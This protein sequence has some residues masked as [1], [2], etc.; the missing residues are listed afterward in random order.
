M[1][2]AGFARI[3]WQRIRSVD[4]LKQGDAAD[5]EYRNL[6]SVLLHGQTKHVAIVGGDAIKI[7]DHHAGGTDVDRCAARSG[8]DCRRVGCIHDA[9]I[10]A[11]WRGDT[12]GALCPV[13]V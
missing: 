7:A 5:A 13:H 10:W 1:I 4:Q 6:P 2:K 11:G 8:G 12:I 3:V 9:N